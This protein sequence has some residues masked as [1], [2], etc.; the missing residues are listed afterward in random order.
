MKKIVYI[1]LLLMI[2]L[3]LN[4]FTFS[5][6]LNVGSEGVD[7]KELQKYLNSNSKTQISDTGAGSPGFETTYFGEKT[8]QAVIKLQ[9]LFAP[10][11]LYPVGLNVGSGF[12]GNSTITFLNNTQGQTTI[13][14][15]FDI[16]ENP[17]VN[18]VSPQELKDGDTITIIGKNFSDKNTVILGF[19]DKY[20]YTNIESTDNGTKIEFTYNSEIQKVYEN[21]YKKLSKDAKKRVLQEFPG[22]DIAVSVIDKDNNQ[23]NFKTITFNLK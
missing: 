12:V 15:I 11:I 8:K 7:V 17:V 20:K 19:E 23:S 10:L 9:N 14:T 2:P 21:N 18:S 13:E 5:R 22:I 3:S 6:S 1:F 16:K 4:A